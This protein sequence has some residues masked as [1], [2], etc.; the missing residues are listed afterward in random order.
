MFCFFV[1][2]YVTYFDRD[3]PVLDLLF[4]GDLVDDGD[5]VDFEVVVPVLSSTHC[6][7]VPS[8]SRRFCSFILS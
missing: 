2:F 3:D 8:N 4:Q 5:F 1:Y 6:P 7:R